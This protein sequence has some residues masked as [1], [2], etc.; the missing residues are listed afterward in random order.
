MWTL[1]KQFGKVLSMTRANVTNQTPDKSGSH[2]PSSALER[3]AAKAI[4]TNEIVLDVRGNTYIGTLATRFAYGAHK[5]PDIF[6]L[7]DSPYH[8][9]EVTAAG[10]IH[11]AA[12]STRE[13]ALR[14]MDENRILVSR[15]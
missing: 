5:L 2:A 11:R 1:R 10:V 3:I 13:L 15:P 7:D 8:V 4:E 6:K 12:Q 9:F 14:Y